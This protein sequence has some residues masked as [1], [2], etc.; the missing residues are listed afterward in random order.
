MIS[1]TALSYAAYTK[2]IFAP[3]SVANWL[4]IQNEKMMGGGDD[5]CA[6]L[7]KSLH[8]EVTHRAIDDM[9]HFSSSDPQQACAAL[10]TKA[11]EIKKT[12]ASQ[13][14]RYENVQVTRHG[15]PWNS[16]DVTYTERL[17]F[18]P[19]DSY[20]IYVKS[21]NQATLQLSWR[22]LQVTRL[23]S[24]TRSSWYPIP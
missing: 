4:R 22:G 9:R 18:A 24:D 12:N 6:P 5:A 21:D 8:I 16:A 2:H 7:A 23:N 11:A 13:Q 20:M 14:L 17:T 1:L 19:P 10:K 15:F 3:S